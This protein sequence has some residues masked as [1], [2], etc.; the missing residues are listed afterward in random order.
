M[1]N[2]LFEKKVDQSLLKSGLTVPVDQQ[3]QIQEA[4]GIHLNK[5]DNVEI[6]ILINDN[7]YKAKLT[8]VNLSGETS[9]RTVFQ[10]RYSENSSI[11]QKIRELFSH[12]DFA[13]GDKDNAAIE[14][15]SG[16]NN[17]LEFKV[18]SDMKEII[19]R[20]LNE[21][22]PAKQE[23]FA[24]HPIG[25]FFRND[26]PRKIYSTG[27]VNS[28]N[29]LITGSVGQGNW[30]MVPWVCIFDRSITT[31]AT[32]GVYIVYLLEKGGNTLYLT[33]NQG[34][35]EIRSTNSKRETI[36]IM[37]EKAADIASKIASRGF[38]TDE[39]INLG[40]GLTELGELY[41]KGTIFYKEYKKIE[42]GNWKTK[43]KELAYFWRQVVVLWFLF[44]LEG[45]L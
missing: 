12:V 20:I 15:F 31:T 22:V 25:T 7:L 26:I 30:A 38:Q 28:E 36:R 27:V 44:T 1:S 29:Y 39:D 45:S 4:V 8:H 42:T 23:T 19:E 11:C 13:N 34:C 37:R 2:F 24:G 32:K 18:K 9:N 41:Q 5:G 40:N 14:V 35:T 10:I 17:T 16:D 3:E 21:Y 33:F 6:E 43:V